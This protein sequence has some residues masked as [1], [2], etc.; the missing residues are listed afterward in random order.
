[1]SCDVDHRKCGF[2]LNA[3]VSHCC[4]VVV[5]RTRSLLR[6]GK[7]Y[8]VYRARKVPRKIENANRKRSP[9]LGS[10]TAVRALNPRGWRYRRRLSSIESSFSAKTTDPLCANPF[11]YNIYFLNQNQVV[12]LARRDVVFLALRILY[13]CS[14]SF[15]YRPCGKRTSSI[16]ITVR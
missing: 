15:F 6:A 10:E 11:R 7:H 13:Y 3:E 12:I 9:Q 14:I 8:P 1:V 4:I 5:F 2:S 16:I